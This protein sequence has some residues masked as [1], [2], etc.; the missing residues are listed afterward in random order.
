MIMI[1]TSHR[2]ETQWSIKYDD[3]DDDTDIVSLVSNIFFYKNRLFRY[4]NTKLIKSI[5]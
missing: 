2:K 5:F 4:A 3:D 1:K